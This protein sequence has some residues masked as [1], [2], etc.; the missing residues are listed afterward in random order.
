MLIMLYIYNIIIY[1]LYLKH[2]F[3][4]NGIKYYVSMFNIE[5]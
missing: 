4:N 3:N 1:Q 5:K 2:E